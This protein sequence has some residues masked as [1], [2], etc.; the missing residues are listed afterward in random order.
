MIAWCLS[1]NEINFHA[2][3]S[4][5][6]CVGVS[7]RTSVKLVSHSRMSETTLCGGQPEHPWLLS[8]LA[9]SASLPTLSSLFPLLLSMFQSG[10]MQCT[11]MIMPHLLSW[12]GTL[13]SPSWWPSSSPLNHQL[14][15]QALSMLC[16]SQ[17]PGDWPVLR[18][19]SLATLCFLGYPSFSG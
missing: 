15:L 19:P 1:H 5:K 13:T 7:K 12:S 2:L 17:Q 8:T 18:A 10:E 14:Q 11:H 3:S 16:S 4:E 6:D 9:H